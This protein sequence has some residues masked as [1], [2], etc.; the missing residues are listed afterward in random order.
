MNKVRTIIV[1][2]ESKARDGLSSMLVKFPEIELI[3]AC[4][5]GLEA[6]DMLNQQQIDLVFLDIQMPGIDGFDVIN[7]IS[8]PKPFVIFVTAFDQYA[9]KAFDHHALD[10]LLKP[11]SDD[12]FFDSVNRAL[13]LIASKK[14]F[15]KET[16]YSDLLAFLSDKMLKRKSLVPSTSNTSEKLVFR[17][18]GKIILLLYSDIYWIEG[19]DYYVKLHHKQGFYLLKESLKIL[20]TKLPE[21]QFTRVHK[22][23]I[24]NITKIKEMV[25]MGHNDYEITLEN[26]ECVKVS[27]NFKNQLLDKINFEP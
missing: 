13:G 7:S 1:D 19:Y 21:S 20:L 26:K 4:K 10:Y 16:D 12:R 5:N 22:S 18:E 3:G 25:P 17:S 23:A 15:T 8:D 2:D 9:I 6:I 11:F 14:E 24:V 27:R